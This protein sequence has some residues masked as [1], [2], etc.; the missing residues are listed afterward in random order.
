MFDEKLEE[1][2]SFTVRYIKTIAMDIIVVLVAVA[3]IFY[4]MVGLQVTEVIQLM[5][6]VAAI[7]GVPLIV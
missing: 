5:L 1:I 6:P 7:V 3:Y 4:Q 2:Q